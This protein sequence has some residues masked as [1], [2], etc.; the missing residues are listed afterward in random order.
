MTKKMTDKHSNLIT[1]LIKIILK[2]IRNY[3]KHKYGFSCLYF[4]CFFNITYIAD[5]HCSLKIVIVCV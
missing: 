5:R 4:L 1:S 3:S 2:N